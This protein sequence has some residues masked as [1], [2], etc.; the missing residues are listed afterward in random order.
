MTKDAATRTL[1]TDTNNNEVVNSFY[2]LGSTLNNEGT[3]SQELH[4]REQLGL[5]KYS[6]V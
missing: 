3:C 4:H 6:D 1:T 5:R 2:L